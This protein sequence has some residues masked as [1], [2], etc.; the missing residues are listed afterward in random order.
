MKLKS[1]MRGVFAAIFAVMLALVVAP[2]T[3]LATQGVDEGG[4]LTVSGLTP[5]DDVAIYQVVTTTYDETSNTLHSEFTHEFGI[6]W[7]QYQ[8]M[9]DDATGSNEFANAMAAYILNPDNHVVATQTAEDVQDASTQFTDLAA[10][11]YLVVVTPD[12]A[13]RVFQNTIASVLPDNVEGEYAIQPG[14]CTVKCTTYNP[15]DPDNPSSLITKTVN[16]A[17]ATDALSV[18]DTA[19]FQI[20]V[21]IPKYMTGST[22]RTVLIEDSMTDGVTYNDASLKVMVGESELK[23]DIDYTAE[24]DGTTFN[25]KL[26]DETIATY[27]GQTLTITYT[28]TVDSDAVYNEVDTNT[29]TLTWSYDSYREGT[30]EASDTVTLSYYQLDVT[31]VDSADSGKVL[32]GA[33]FDVYKADNTKLGTITTANG[34]KASFGA[35]GAGA[36]Y[37]V[38]TKAPTGYDLDTTRKD[39][40]ITSDDEPSTAGK[41]H[42]LTISNTLSKATVLPETGGTG[43]VALTVVGV[44][45]MAGAAYLVVRSRKEN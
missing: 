39:F 2:S 20:N 7:S 29:A 41:V 25:V 27:G 3:A 34:G 21:A 17:E 33:T 38:E 37:L 30:L 15:E 32:D 8:A 4:T 45:L 11:Q 19:N 12:V 14:S 31:K 10:G 40:T 6:D 35:L 22:G 16:N 5:G 9:Q 24:G 1:R 28:G 23:A 44:G 42:S 13:N 26:S 18:N 43:T 36:Y